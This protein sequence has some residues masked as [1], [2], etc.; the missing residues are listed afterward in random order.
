MAARKPALLF[1]FIT[2]FLDI[3]GIGL[4][5]PILPK[6]VENFKGGDVESAAHTFGLLAALYS[7][8]QFIF[9]PILGAL[10]DRFGRRPVILASLFG[11]GID[12]L[13]LAFAPNLGWFVLGRIISGIMGASFTA[14]AAYIADISP[15]EKRA[16]SMGIIGAAFGLGFIAGPALGGLL[17]EYGLRVPFFAAAG[18]T[19]INWLYGVFVLPESLAKENRRA[20]D[21]RRANPIG[22]LLAL[23][24]YP[25]VFGLAGTWFVFQLAHQV[26]PSNWVLYTENRY[27]WGPRETG[28]SLALVGVMAAVVQGGFTRKIIPRIG[29][30]RAVVV[31]LVISVIAFTCYGLATRG[32]MIYPIIVVGA[33][34]GIATPALQGMIS[35]SVRADEQG[36]VQGAL[37]SLSSVAG[38]LGPPLA[39]SLFG[40]FIS[41]KA[42]VHLPGAA[43]FCSALL[44]VLALLL[45]IRSFRRSRSRLAMGES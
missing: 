24:R 20:L 18:L 9:S 35:N 12:Y 1:I 6:L 21:W 11:G 28:L 13:L 4:I 30:P 15:P 25:V 31:G 32:W 44:D 5:I 41:T 22:A 40:Y 3:V 29:E 27:G 37:T 17:G 26:F 7:L 45:A 16:Q 34:M 38:I 36:E 8:M 33:F 23:K 14:G 19:L 43:F 39:T 42:P 2:L 10:S